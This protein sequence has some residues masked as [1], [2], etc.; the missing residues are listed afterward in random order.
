MPYLAAS[1]AIP[2]IFL[3]FSL[4][5]YFSST[6][7]S[8]PFKFLCQNMPQTKGLSP[9]GDTI[10]SIAAPKTAKKYPVACK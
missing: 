10:V 2:F 5:F 7:A 6:V 1:L 9:C 8:Q 3:F 4:L